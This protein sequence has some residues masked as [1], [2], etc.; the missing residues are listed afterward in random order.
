[1]SALCVEWRRG[2]GTGA[3][4]CDHNWINDVCEQ[5]YKAGVTFYDKREIAVHICDR[6]WGGREWPAE[7]KA[8]RREP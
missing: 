7:W 5:C 8:E 3:S 6:V 4:A 1:M 2:N